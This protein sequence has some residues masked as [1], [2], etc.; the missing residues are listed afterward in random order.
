[1]NYLHDLNDE[2]RE[3][4]LHF[5]SPLLILAG[6]GSGKTR[7]ITTKIAYLIA[8][9]K[10][11]PRS[12]LAVTF[13]NKAASE[14]KNRVLSMVEGADDVMIKT[15][16]SFGAWLL[17]RYAEQ[18]GLNKNF[19]IYDEDDK[20]ALIKS[21]VER[22]ESRSDCKHYANLISRA[23]D[24]C[25]LPNDDL[26]EL[27][28]DPHF[29]KIYDRYENKLKEMGNADFGDLI[30]KPL[31]LLKGNPELKSRLQN[32][33]SVILVDEFQDSNGAQL[34]LLKELYS[35]E[36]YLCVV[37]DEDQSIYSFRGALVQNIVEFPNIFKNTKV[38]MLERN[39]RST[40]NILDIAKNVVSK[41][42][43]RLGKN[44]WTE[45]KEGEPVVFALLEN[46]DE[47]AQFAAQLLADGNMKDT[48]ILYRNNYQSRAFEALFTRMHIP[49]RIVGTLKFYEREE[50]K[51]VLS[52]LNFIV[53]QRDEV[54]FKRI[55][56][57]P[58][59][60]IGEK[61]IETIISQHQGDLLLSC[62][63][64]L[65]TLPKK[66]REGTVYFIKV[67]EEMRAAIESHTLAETIQLL[68]VRSG[69]RDYYAEEDESHDTAKLENLDELIN[70]A[71]PYSTGLGGL[72]S[73]LESTVLNSSDED[74]Y[75]HENKVTL[76][77]M[78]NTKGLE[79]DRVMISGLEEELF[80]HIR[81]TNE[82]AESDLE[83][84]RRLFYV[85]ITRAKKKLFITS[86]RSRLVFGQYRQRIVSRFIDEIPRD[87]LQI[88]K[89][90]TSGSAYAR[91]DR[92]FHHKY[93]E[94]VITNAW[95]NEGE[96]FV[97]MRLSDGRCVQVMLA[98]TRLEKI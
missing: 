35:G 16:H 9:K 64:A 62:K 7:V 36:N 58:T 94:G 34:E 89:R 90:D 95:V 30:L 26:K 40:I 66:A 12:I 13:T 59:R 88:M 96:E 54:S 72:E 56:N 81:D 68:S 60:G 70:A 78:H 28:F 67:I 41:N 75:E 14:M 2:Q 91:G 84:E 53:N 19:T 3:A 93:G 22:G 77:T 11:D 57:K 10:F 76:I 24:N 15:F 74:P 23:K 55:V 17:R 85:A 42:E 80:P 48:A 63:A 45:T 69:L 21:L 52:Y 83:E 51:D 50:V 86:C 43:Y 98:Y 82:D 5:G 61:S 29:P 97:M 27:S 46:Q 6:A 31:L 37:G 47:E 65:E 44:L 33:F 4:V 20:L 25:L 87:L 32:R 1:M 49:Y 18:A 38:I 71:Q 39:Y 8:E 92:V 73:F 79:F